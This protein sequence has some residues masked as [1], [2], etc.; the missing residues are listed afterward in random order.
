MDEFS[1]FPK[2]PTETRIHI[3]DLAIQQAPWS[4]SRVRWTH[5]TAPGRGK[6]VPKLVGTH[7][8]SIAHVSREARDAVQ[9][10]S[11]PFPAELGS[12]A[13]GRHLF[14]FNDTAADRGLMAA[15][16][17]RYGLFERVRHVVLMP[18]CWSKCVKTLDF[19]V[20]RCR[21]LETL[22][23]VA[24]W[25][26]PPRLP[27]H[28]DEL[29]VSCWLDRDENPLLDGVPPDYSPDDLDL[30]GLVDKIDQGRAAA[31]EDLARYR[32]GVE[33]AAAATP[34]ELDGDV[35]TSGDDDRLTWISTRRRLRMLDVRVRKFKPSAPSVILLRL[36]E[37]MPRP[38][39][40]ER[41]GI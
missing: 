16:D 17:K 32:D 13:L 30:E 37:L 25:G 26:E 11:T 39:D 21:A 31:D 36:D 15:V 41:E 10:A 6:R 23:V 27:A 4:C 34:T 8:R 5:T 18:R 20:E 19:L 33:G 1:L 35:L 2:L 24:F 29:A 12:L 38:A 40:G 28:I 22:V 14:F 3:W 7:N 9:R